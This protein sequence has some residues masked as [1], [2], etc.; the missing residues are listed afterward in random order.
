LQTLIG[1]GTG[2]LFINPLM[3]A[4]LA[5]YIAFGPL[6]INTYHLLFPRP[7]LYMSSFC[8]IFGNFFYVY[9][10]LLACMRRKEYRLIPWI[11]CIPFYWALI[12]L[13]G[14]IALFELLV[15]PHYWQ[16]TVHGLHLKGKQS[17]SV[18]TTRRAAPTLVEGPTMRMPTAFAQVSERTVIPTVTNSLKAIS[19]LLVPAVSLAQKQARHTAKQSKVR[20]LWLVTTFFTACITSIIACWYYFQQHQILLY[21]DAYSHMRIARSVFDSA[22]PGIAQ[23]GG[24]WLPLPHVLML[25]FIWNNYLW[26]S[27]LAG[28]FVSMLGYVAS[29]IFLYLSA[30]R[31]TKNG[32]M[33]F[34]GTLLFILNPNILYL[35]STP[36]SELVCIWTLTMACYYFLLWAQEDALRYLVLAAASTFLA[37]IAR[38]LCAFA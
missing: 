4:M 19:T 3:W 21:H 36:L 37:T 2:V 25:P 30:Q 22:T 7:V 17:P 33:S 10:Y 1:S 12:S 23:L 11:L 13:A 6:V 31:L 8:L 20:D 38:S 5:I 18:V 35:Q 14:G 28:S 16:K 24:V 15:N 27:G 29:A 32:C 26:H 34:L 9:L